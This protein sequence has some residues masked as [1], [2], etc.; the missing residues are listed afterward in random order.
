M[1]TPQE[2]TEKAFVKAVFGGYDMSGVD[3]FLETVTNDYTALYKENAILKGKLKVLVEKVEEYRSTEDSMRMALLT[4]Q[5]VGEEIT[6]EANKQREAVLRDAGAEIKSRLADTA[7]RIAEE[8]MRLSVAA[9]ETSKFIELSLALM[10]RHS[11]FLTKIEAARKAVVQNHEPPPAPAPP[12][13]PPRP[14]HDDRIMDVAD[15]IGDAVQRITNSDPSVPTVTARSPYQSSDITA[16]AYTQ[17]FAPQPVVQS[18][19]QPI[20][21]QTHFDT[22]SAPTLPFSLTGEDESTSPRPKFDFDDLK[23]GANFDSVR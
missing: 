7:Q 20:P 12:P 5:R 17:A 8:E 18:Y 21:A 23:F 1:L 10:R 2:I 11:E 14:T 3:E 19:T 22:G 13:P 15:Q 6:A 16:S 4:A 9:K